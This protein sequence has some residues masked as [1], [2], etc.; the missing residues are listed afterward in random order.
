MHIDYLGTMQGMYG[1]DPGRFAA[2]VG[3]SL[4]LNRRR[5]PIDAR[6]S[7][8]LRSFLL[9][10][11]G[12]DRVWLGPAAHLA[13]NLQGAAQR[14]GCSLVSQLERPARLSG[15][16]GAA[17]ASSGGSAGEFAA[18][19]KQAATAFHLEESDIVDS[20]RLLQQA[21]HGF[22]VIEEP[23]GDYGNRQH[24]RFH[25]HGRDVAI[26]WEPYA[27]EEEAVA[28]SRSRMST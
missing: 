25:A 21:G 5:A 6:T 19:L 22:E 27:V 10:F 2:L 4:G 28:T 13:M 7:I 12:I 11:L 24:A 23:H 20:A 3:C 9:H 26:A 14:R 17:F 18:T 15:L 1:N 8:E 16:A